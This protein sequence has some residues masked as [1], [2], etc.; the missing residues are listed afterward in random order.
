VI[1][2]EGGSSA[3]AV[4]HP[5]SS[6]RRLG[7]SLVKLDRMSEDVNNISKHAAS[8]I[9]G[10]LPHSVQ[11]QGTRHLCIHVTTKQMLIC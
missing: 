10:G 2:R 6:R 3:T 9:P 7:H 11:I 1:R 4:Y 8:D 5:S